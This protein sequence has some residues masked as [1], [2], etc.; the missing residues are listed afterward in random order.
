MYI[1]QLR[2]CFM[3]NRKTGSFSV[4]LYFESS[5]TK[6][7]FNQKFVHFTL[8]S[9][10]NVWPGY[11]L[12]IFSQ[13][14]PCASNWNSMLFL[15]PCQTHISF[16]NGKLMQNQ[17][18]TIECQSI[19]VFTKLHKLNMEVFWSGGRI[20]FHVSIYYNVIAVLS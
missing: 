14:I 1:M 19:E 6:N 9:W 17:A 13:M 20:S 5:R 16:S 4:D 15:I 7:S 8:F 11:F 18:N 12:E 3:L 2:K 10:D